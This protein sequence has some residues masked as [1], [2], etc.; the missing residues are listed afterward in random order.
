VLKYLVRVALGEIVAAGIE[1]NVLVV[2]L[3]RFRVLWRL[4][5]VW[6]MFF[7]P[8]SNRLELNLQ[9]GPELKER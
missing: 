6:L 5:I 8:T 2:R 9:L 4:E 7:E 1:Q 3:V